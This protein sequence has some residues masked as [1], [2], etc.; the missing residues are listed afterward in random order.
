IAARAGAARPID[1]P[2]T[3]LGGFPRL[4]EPR[5]LWLGPDERWEHEADARLLQSLVRAIDE[6]CAPHGIAPEKRLFSPHLTLG[7]VKTG[8]RHIGRA[9]A[10][11]SG[12]K[13]LLALPALSVSAI[14]LMKSE[15][16]SKGA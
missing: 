11:R 3:R 15:L 4:Q 14:A 13:A 6:S 16:D 5:S 2:L 9:L 12:A 10:A 8:E 1:V 7:R